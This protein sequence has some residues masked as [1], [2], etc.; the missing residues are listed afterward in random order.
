MKQSHLRRGVCALFCAVMIVGALLLIGCS[1]GG[2]SAGAEGP[3]GPSGST[4]PTG[5]AGGVTATAETCEVCHT[6]GKIADIAMFHPDPT[7]LDVTI[8]SITLTNTVGVG[9]P[10]VSFHAETSD[11]LPVT[12]LTFDDVRFFIADLVPAGTVTH[13]ENTLTGLFTWD[14]SYFERWA[15]E[16]SST[17]G[18]SFDTTN[19]AA[20]NYTYHFATG[21]ADASTAAPD[22]NQNHT[23]RL[24]I[25][26]SGQND[27]VTGLAITNNTVG[28]LDFVTPTL[29]GPVTTSVSQRLFVTADACKKCHSPLFQQAHHADVYLDTRT[30]VIC[31]SPLGVYGTGGRPDMVA[32][33]AYLPVLIHQIH[34]SIVGPKFDWSDVTFPQDV[35]NCVLCHTNSNLNLG[36]GNEIDH[37]KT[38]PT[39]EVCVSCHTDVNPITGDNH[40][41]GAQ[42]NSACTVCHKDS[43]QSTISLVPIPA[44]HDTTPREAGTDGY[45]DVDGYKPENIPEFNVMLTITDPANGSYYVA[46]EEPEVR[47]TLTDH[48]TSVP[49]LS[50]VYTT[51]QDLAGVAGGGLNVASLYVYGPRAKAVPV[52]ASGSAADPPTQEHLLFKNS[53][54]PQVTTNSSGF[55]YQLLAIPA[56]MKA[57]TYMVRVRIGDYGRV[58]DNNY[59]IE[60]TAFRNIQIGTATAEDKV[61]GNNCMDCHGTGTAPFHDSRHAVVFDTDQCLACHD[62]SGNFA[63]PLADRVHAVHSANP[64]GDIYNIEAGSISSDRD[65]SDVT[66]PQDLAQVDQNGNPL[67]NDP[68]CVGCHSSGD[69]TYKTLPYMMPCVGCHTVDGDLDHMRQNGGPF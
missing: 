59:R 58:N 48:A 68:R 22:Y 38:N 44:A 19:A 29:G 6:A 31:H 64:S 33:D 36:T 18:A 24:A 21:F 51:K 54:D 53:S 43:G 69:D 23:Q 7:G 55:G 26:V 9:I 20:G 65:W 63:I 12:N 46:G 61:A 25:I 32:D 57:G 10:V 1:N 5:P 2:G 30:C 35:R 14:S 67:Y 66:Y 15:S 50:A 11:G 13:Y 37:W 62:Q 34:D 3:A 40:Q 28:F 17:A 49:V 39:A 27:P 60:S 56:D 16:S 41:G 4:G 8:S 52:L 42:P 47:V 45:W